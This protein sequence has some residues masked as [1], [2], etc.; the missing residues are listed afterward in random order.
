MISS[1]IESPADYSLDSFS[2]CLVQK[3][4]N[5][6]NKHDTNLWCQIYVNIHSIQRHINKIITLLTFEKLE[7]AIFQ[8]LIN[9]AII[10]AV[11]TTATDRTEMRGV[12]INHHINHY[13]DKK[14]CF[15]ECCSRHL[16]LSQKQMIVGLETR[17]LLFNST[18][19]GKRT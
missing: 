7:S 1:L 9:R 4:E 12:I 10:T 16:L 8:L 2:N 18:N 5:I 3:L 17:P 14:Q 15:A 11:L 13:L 19:Y 6:N